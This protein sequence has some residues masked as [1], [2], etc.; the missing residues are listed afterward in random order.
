MVELKLDF[1]YTAARE[2]EFST[3]HPIDKKIFY[4]FQK[5]NLI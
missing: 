3:S 1:K 5:M 2:K 4:K